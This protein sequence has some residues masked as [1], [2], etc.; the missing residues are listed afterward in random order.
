MRAPRFLLGLVALSVLVLAP[1]TASA[2]I[3]L[4]APGAVGASPCSPAPCDLATAVNGADDGDQVVLAPGLYNLE[5][6]LKVEKAIDVG[7]RPGAA[8]SVVLGSGDGALVENPGATLHDV[9]LALAKETMGYALQMNGGTVERVY[10]DGSNGVACSVSEG[11]MRN[12]ACFGSL[13]VTPSGVGS[14]QATLSNVTAD[15]LLFG[16]FEGAKL[17]ATATNAIGLPGPGLGGS[18][19]GVAIDVS[20][21][22]SAS[23]VLANSN[24]AEVDTSL[25]SGNNFSF[26]APGTNGNQ[27]ASAQ[28][29]NPATGDFRPLENSPTIDGGHADPLLGPFDLDG[30][31][32][33]QA[34]C[35]GGTPIP[36]IGAYE[37]T[38]TVAC[39]GPAPIA[40][41]PSSRFKFGKLTRKPVKGTV[42]LRVR[43]PG[44]GKVS[45]RG[46]GLVRR[47]AS[48]ARAGTVRLLIKAK[49]AKAREL[50]RTGRVRVRPLVTFTPSGGGPRQMPRPLVLRFSS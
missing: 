38:P 6:D 24:Y 34:R 5:V 18:K 17:T 16:A 22:S 21:G 25:S 30:A 7:G 50:R 23:I 15:P 9:R 33:V 27:T 48:T 20:T 19:A 12:S 3:R 11:T 14:F 36:D 8:A 47:Q 43:V 29:A 46:K 40:E 10:A 4:A 2:A 32:R 31:A 42:L 41:P 26:T 39:P 49:G 13:N 1:A 44:P 28:L 45:L 35:L 37:F